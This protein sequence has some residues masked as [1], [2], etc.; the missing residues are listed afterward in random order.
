M[1]TASIV[2]SFVVMIVAA[3][4]SGGFRKEI[5]DAL[6]SLAGDVSVIPVSTGDVP[7]RI[8][9]SADYVDQFSQIDGVQS[10]TPVLY[11]GG[12]LRK[13]ENVHGVLFKASDGTRFDNDMGV[14]IPRRLAE[15][16]DAEQND[17]LTA[18]FVGDHVVLRRFDVVD[19]YD[20]IVT[21]DDKLVV[22]CDASMLRRVLDYGDDE[23]SSLEIALTPSHKK[24]GDIQGVCNEVS[25]ML[26]ED[27]HE[28]QSTLIAYTRRARYSALFDWLDLIDMNVNIIMLLMVIVAGFNM[29]CALLILL[30]QNIRTIGVLK[31]LG[32]SVRDIVRTFL[33]SSARTVGLAMIYGNISAFMLCWIQDCFH[34]IRLDPQSYFLSYVP[35]DLD[36]AFVVLCDCIGFAAIMA[37]LLVPCTFISK[38]QASRSVDYR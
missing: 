28:D 15:I 4:I 25:F 17:K 34:V 10:V 36:P 2:V 19:I 1:A 9:H 30:F 6:T 18:Y 13:G 37:V 38:V 27:A 23:S 26:Y 12:M 29:V 24:D 11:S 20:G 22:L 31:T 21:D 16:L 14:R 8:M 33:I 35:I 3:A 32:M 7:E 5:S